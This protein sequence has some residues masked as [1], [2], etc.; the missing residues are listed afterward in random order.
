MTILFFVVGVNECES[1]PCN[2]HRCL[3]KVNGYVCQ[4]NKG[5]NGKNCEIKP[6][7][8]KNDPCQNEAICANTP[9]GNYTCTCKN[10]FKGRRC[11]KKIGIWLSWE[12][13]YSVKAV[14]KNIVKISNAFVL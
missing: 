5:Y 2:G 9:D 11:E 6:D 10:G 14:L 1:D 4:C 8:C 3:N 12:L 13:F 7:Y